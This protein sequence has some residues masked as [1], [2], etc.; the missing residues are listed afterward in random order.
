MLSLIGDSI[1][2]T[3]VVGA[4]LTKKSGDNLK[5]VWAKLKTSSWIFLLCKKV[6]LNHFTLL[7]LKTW[8]C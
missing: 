5:V 7:K 1:F 6:D 4:V 2:P 8:S 3:L